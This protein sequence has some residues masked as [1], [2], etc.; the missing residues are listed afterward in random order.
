MEGFSGGG[1]TTTR[2]GPNDASHVVWALGE[3]F[4]N[5]LHV[6]FGYL[7]IYIGTTDSLKVQCGSTQAKTTTTG[8]NDT[9]H[10]VWA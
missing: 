9:S 10:T 4:F 6:F 8:P 5:L 2:T 3:F 7:T 1:A